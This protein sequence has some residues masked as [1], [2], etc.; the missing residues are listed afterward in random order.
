VIIFLGYFNDFGTVSGLI[1]SVRAYIT[2]ILLIPYVLN[3]GFQLL[4]HSAGNFY[5][6]DKSTGAIVGQQPFGGAFIDLM[7]IYFQSD[8]LCGYDCVWC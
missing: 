3:S 6:N 7:F 4:R 2:C 8:A 1:C 5:L